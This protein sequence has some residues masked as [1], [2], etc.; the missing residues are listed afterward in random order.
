MKGTEKIIAHIKADAEAEAQAVIAKALQ[1]AEAISAKDKKAA[2]DEYEK[3]IRAG[4]TECEAYFERE[5]RVAEMEA[6]KSVL[7]AK[8]DRVSAVFD[9]ALEQ[10]CAMP[11]EAYAAF[12]AK[13]AASAS[14]GGDEQLIF[15][16]RDK[17]TVAAEVIAQANAL[18]TAAG[19]AGKLAVSEKT[20]EFA[21]GFV[22]TKGGIETNCTLETL[23]EM[24]RND[25]VAPVAAV[26]FE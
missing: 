26:L 5:K 3:C 4:Q 6:K 1:E 11:A 20:G 25:M 17:G 12:L 24:S 9:K 23:V 8:Q 15:N 2:Q 18:L 10:L 22:L 19:K 7:Q 13:K 16:A 14:E 21:G